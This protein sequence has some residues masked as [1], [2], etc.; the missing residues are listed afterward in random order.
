MPSIFDD[1]IDF[2]FFVTSFSSDR[3][4]KLRGYE[5]D[6]AFK[7]DEKRLDDEEEIEEARKF[8]VIDDYISR[9]YSYF[10]LSDW[11]KII[12]DLLVSLDT[13]TNVIEKLSQS[14]KSA[15]TLLKNDREKQVLMTEYHS[16][17]PRHNFNQR[18]FDNAKQRVAR[19]TLSNLSFCCNTL[20]QN[21]ASELFDQLKELVERHIETRVAEGP[22][23]WFIG[24]WYFRGPEFYDIFHTFLQQTIKKQGV[25]SN[26]TYNTDTI[27]KIFLRYAQNK[28]Y[29]EELFRTVQN[30]DKV[31]LSAVIWQSL[32]EEKDRIR[33]IR[34]VLKH[35]AFKVNIIKFK[36][37]NRIDIAIWSYKQ[38]VSIQ[39]L[40]PSTYQPF[41]IENKLVEVRQWTLELLQER[42]TEK[43]NSKAAIENWL[44]YSDNLNNLSV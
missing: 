43:P 1:S 13:D 37:G 29:N 33:Y 42:I 31:G 6:N 23:H 12:T 22:E 28:N 11:S 36:N 34:K 39:K 24:D 32:D 3:V 18:L 16:L 30:I 15:E 5:L 41:L 4:N 9:F 38:N 44:E 14:D 27:C 21:G 40:S 19:E 25:D 26:L 7:L 20:K 2:N 17:N 8:K 10:E 35:P